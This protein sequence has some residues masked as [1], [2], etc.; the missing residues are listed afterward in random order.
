MQAQVLHSLKVLEMEEA[1][2]DRTIDIKKIKGQY[3]KLAIK[4]HPDA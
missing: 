1:V 3:L 4:Y 2:K